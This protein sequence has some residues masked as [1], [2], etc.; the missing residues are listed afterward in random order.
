MGGFWGG[1]TPKIHGKP[2]SLFVFSLPLPALFIRVN[3]LSPSLSPSFTLSPS[4]P[5]SL[6]HSLTPSLSLSLLSF[7]SCLT[8]SPNAPLHFPYSF[9]NPSPFFP[10]RRILRPLVV[11]TVADSLFHRRSLVHRASVSATPAFPSRP[12][13]NRHL[14]ATAISF[15]PRCLNVWLVETDVFRVGVIWRDLA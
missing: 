14:V 8:E 3:P 6:P 10:R 11:S 5:H 4:L 12:C 13:C 9:P 1:R 7:P 2:V 15:C